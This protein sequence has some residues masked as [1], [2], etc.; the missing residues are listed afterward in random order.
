VIARWRKSWVFFLST[1]D[2]VIRQKNCCPSEN[3]HK[4]KPQNLTFLEC[5]ILPVIRQG[6]KPPESIE[7]SLAVYCKKKTT[8]NAGGSKKL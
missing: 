7:N 3:F 5:I 2:L 6:D 4:L 1:T 8:G